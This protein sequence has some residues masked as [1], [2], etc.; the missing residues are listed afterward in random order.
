MAGRRCRGYH[1]GQQQQFLPRRLTVA[2]V[3]VLYRNGLFYR[4][5]VLIARSEPQGMSFIETANLDGETNLKIRQGVPQTH[6]LLEPHMLQSFV[7]TLECEPPNRHLYE[8]T[9]TLRSKQYV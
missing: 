7:G 6:S 4:C 9:G 5:N 1:K 8:F 3:Q 2:V